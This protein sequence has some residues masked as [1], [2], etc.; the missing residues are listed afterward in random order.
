MFS[1]S[2]AF[3]AI[4]L[5]T[6]LSI[7]SDVW[8]IRQLIRLT[9][10]STVLY[11]GKR[12]LL[13]MRYHVTLHTHCKVSGI[14]KSRK[15]HYNRSLFSNL[16]I[17][18]CR[19]KI[20]WLNPFSFLRLIWINIQRG[21]LGWHFRVKL[22]LTTYILK[23]HIILYTPMVLLLWGMMRRRGHFVMGKQKFCHLLFYTG[24]EKRNWRKWIAKLKHYVCHHNAEVN[25]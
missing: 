22:I 19:L 25:W 2:T 15:K 10:I 8:C 21:M 13:A 4:Y 12:T 17:N 5:Q 1:D 24:Y 23:V 3:T 9:F 16:T 20:W 6:F 14:T 11:N 18:T 7:V